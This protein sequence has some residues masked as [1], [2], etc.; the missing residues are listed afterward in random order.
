MWADSVMREQSERTAFLKAVAANPDDDLPRL[1][2]ADWLEE[3]SRLADRAR[4]QFIRGQI[5][6]E[7]LD[8]ESPS[9]P[10]AYFELF[11]KV[12]SAVDGYALE[13]LKELTRPAALELRR[14]RVGPHLFRRGF[15]ERVRMNAK[16]FARCAAHLFATAPV[17]EA[18]LGVDVSSA[19]KLFACPELLRLRLMRISRP[20]MRHRSRGM[21]AALARCPFL[22]N[23]REL[24]LSDCGLDDHDA[25]LLS[26]AKGLT[27]LDTLKLSGNRLTYSGVV[28]LAQ[29]IDL[30][31]V[32]R[33]ELGRNVRLDDWRR[34]LKRWYGDRLVF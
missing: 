18:H 25:Q 7:R 12:C 24:D 9:Y 13:W 1:V 11:P 28:A 31:H 3:Q 4:G 23:V 10:W 5:E 26:R 17:T 20:V 27:A 19:G 32:R 14:E 22:T 2:F 8:R 21:M 6:L 33:I 16:T 15:V 30:Q 34:E 29:T